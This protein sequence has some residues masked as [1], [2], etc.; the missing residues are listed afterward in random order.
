[1]TTTIPP[2]MDCPMLPFFNNYITTPACDSSKNLLDAFLCQ[3]NLP[4]A[5]NQMAL[6]GRQHQFSDCAFAPSLSTSSTLTSQL[7]AEVQQRYAM[8]A[9]VLARQNSSQFSTLP[10]LLASALLPEFKSNSAPTFT[11]GLPVSSTV[12]ERESTFRVQDGFP[13]PH[14]LLPSSTSSGKRTRDTFEQ[15]KDQHFQSVA[16]SEGTRNS[17]IALSPGSHVSTPEPRT[18]SAGSEQSSKKRRFDSACSVACSDEAEDDE[19]SSEE[20]RRSGSQS[21][22]RSA[23]IRWTRAEHEQFLEGLERFGVG[24]WCSIARHCVPS[25]S[26]AQ[27]A[28]HHQKFAIRSNMPPERRHK[29]S[30]LDITT[31]KVQSLVAAAQRAGE[32]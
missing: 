13:Q 28:S 19:S 24:Q 21:T 20:E 29:A 1:M 11:Y 22:K 2:L 15:A 4:V 7:I 6:M 23:T 16:Q 18:P 3:R 5:M 30:L 12:D 25:R 9:A 14:A 26:P 32:A 10:P 27:V 31:P 8:T 17:P